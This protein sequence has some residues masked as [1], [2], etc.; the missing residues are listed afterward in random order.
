MIARSKNHMALLEYVGSCFDVYLNYDNRT[1]K[2]TDFTF[3]LPAI[4]TQLENETMGYGRAQLSRL[5][6]NF[7]RADVTDFLSPLP[8][9]ASEIKLTIKHYLWSNPDVYRIYAGVAESLPELTGSYDSDILTITVV[10]ILGV[11]GSGDDIVSED[12]GEEYRFISVPELVAAFDAGYGGFVRRTEP[13]PIQIR[14]ADKWWSCLFRPYKKRILSSETYD[15]TVKPKSLCTDGTY[16]YYP[17]HNWI[18]RFDP[19]TGIEKIITKIGSGN[20]CLYVE[21]DSGDIHFITRET[22]GKRGYGSFTI[23]TV[24]GAV[25]PS[26]YFY[27]YD[28]GLEVH[29]KRILKHNHR[30]SGDSDPALAT[31]KTRMIG[32][33]VVPIDKNLSCARPYRGVR[34]NVELDV[35]KGKN[36]VPITGALVDIP[37][38]IATAWVDFIGWHLQIEDPI[39]DSWQYLGLCTKFERYDGYVWV[40]FERPLEFDLTVAAP[41]YPR[42]AAFPPD[43]WPSHNLYIPAHMK[44]AVTYEKDELSDRDIQQVVVEKRHTLEDQP[45]FFYPDKIGEIDEGDE[46]FIEP[47]VYSFTSCD[48][49]EEFTNNNG[50]TEY[51]ADDCAAFMLELDWIDRQGQYLLADGFKVENAMQ[52][53][54]YEI[55]GANRVTYNGVNTYFTNGDKVE[56]YGNIYLFKDAGGNIYVGVNEYKHNNQSIY[57][58]IR[59]GIWIAALGRFTSF[60]ISREDDTGDNYQLTS[61]F[62]VRD[63]ILYGGAKLYNKNWVKTGL[64]VIYAR[65]PQAAEATRPS[66]YDGGTTG[67]ICVLGDQSDLFEAGGRVR[68]GNTATGDALLKEY[69]ISEVTVTSRQFNDTGSAY[70]VSGYE[71]YKGKVTAIFLKN[72]A[73]RLLW[74]GNTYQEQVV[75]ELLG[76]YVTVMQGWDI[77]SVSYKYDN[78]FTVIDTAT[79]SAGDQPEGQEN[80]DGETYTVSYDSDWPDCPRIELNEDRVLTGVRVFLKNQELTGTDYTDYLV[81]PEPPKG[82]FYYKRNSGDYSQTYIYFNDLYDNLEVRV[83]YDYYPEDVEYRAFTIFK[84][85]IYYQETGDL[86]KWKVYNPQIRDAGAD[87]YSAGVKENAFYSNVVE[88]DNKLY[89]ITEPSYTLRQFDNRWSGYIEHAKTEG[90]RAWDILSYIAS[91]CN[92]AL[93]EMNSDYIFKRRDQFTYRGTLELHG[94]IKRTKIPPYKKVTISY[95]NGQAVVGEGKP[96]YTRSC[97]YVSDYRHALIIANAV[98]NFYSTGV[99]KYEIEM[100][101]FRDDIEMLD[102]FDFYYEGKKITGYV[103]AKD[104]Y[105]EPPWKSKIVIYEYEEL[106]V[107]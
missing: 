15:N 56:S 18:V 53:N 7:D 87:S 19:S 55:C 54:G 102:M 75:Q 98:Y 10:S 51:V 92:N 32:N 99:N 50:H 62:V 24:G 67:V 47:G 23:A 74:H 76:K 79:Y 31:W 71:T 83:E 39:S 3:G 52:P 44:L 34:A 100:L 59:F 22:A 66:N 60:Y 5:S 40:F 45:S 28:E 78:D 93:Y 42:L 85:K 2:V 80:E 63:F 82:E 61:P 38:G 89:G 94:Q 57:S 58:R 48:T 97:E 16:I 68:V 95:P 37:D 103:V 1:L 73:P 88:C 46:I 96:G 91:A 43:I 72:L 29:S 70:T 69:F 17:V 107:N 77:R 101:T 33:G 90:V 9:D 49:A 41:V 20:E 6:V 30:V 27:K 4:S 86:N 11:L 104:L 106:N 8:E 13:V 35:Y 64:Q 12:T 36:N 105:P 26:S 65:P 81:V 14:A 25:S 84:D 21:Y